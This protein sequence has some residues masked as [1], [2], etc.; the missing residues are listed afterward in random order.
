MIRRPR[1]VSFGRNNPLRYGC[2]P[3]FTT[4]P[5][6]RQEVQTRIFLR[7]PFSVT[8]RAGCRL[9]SQRRLVRLL[10]WLT[11]FPARGPF[12]QTAQTA[13]IIEFW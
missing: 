9:G 8:I 1:V 3:A 4:L 11:L 2:Y 10:A 13:A 12:P 6:E 5:A 7:V